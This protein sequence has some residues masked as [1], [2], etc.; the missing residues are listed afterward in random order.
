M[1]V[2]V[3]LASFDSLAFIISPYW[4]RIESTPQMVLVLSLTLLAGAIW[5]S[6]SAHDLHVKGDPKRWKSLLCLFAIYLLLNLKP[7]LS[8]IPWRGDEDYH[9]QNTLVLASQISIKWLLAL[10]EVLFLLIYLAWQESKWT[11]PAGLLCLAGLITMMWIQSP[12]AA[13]KDTILFRYPYVNYWFFALHPK[14]ALL[15]RAAPYQEILFRLVPFLASLALVWICQTYFLP[16]TKPLDLL[17]GGA[18][19]TLPLLY[20]YSSILYLELLLWC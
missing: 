20:Y 2:T 4:R 12:L 13:V 10:F 1:L 16:P 9:I 15:L 19:V 3:L 7:L 8:V 11:A 17:W 18:F 6:L 14:L 5:V